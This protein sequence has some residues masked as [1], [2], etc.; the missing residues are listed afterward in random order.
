MQLGRGRP[1]TGRGGVRNCGGARP[2]TPAPFWGGSGAGRDRS[3]WVLLQGDVG[4]WGGEGFPYPTSLRLGEA[5][6]AGGG[7]ARGPGGGWAVVKAHAVSTS[8]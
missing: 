4:L 7:R 6:V 8:V 2:S 5:G 1:G 3:C